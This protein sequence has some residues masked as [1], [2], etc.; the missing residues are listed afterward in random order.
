MAARGGTQCPIPFTDSKQLLNLIVEFR[1]NIKPTI[2][3]A[4]VRIHPIHAM[5]NL[6]HDILVMEQVAK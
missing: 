5:F 3:N 2:L 4:V 6:C 1:L